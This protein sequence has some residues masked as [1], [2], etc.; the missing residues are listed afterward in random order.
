MNT[1]SRMESTGQR[2]KIQVSQ[3]TADL[4]LSFNKGSWLKKR[5]D[6]DSTPSETS[7]WLE[8]NTR[9]SSVKSGSTYP[10]S[11]PS[12]KEDVSCSLSRD[13]SA[14]FTPELLARDCSEYVDGA[15][16]LDEKTQRMVNWITRLLETLLCKVI[17]HRN[18]TRGSQLP[19]A[20][21]Q[22]TLPTQAETK[23]TVIDEVQDIIALPQQKFPVPERPPE[24][25]LHLG[26]DVLDQL[27]Y[28]VSIIASKYKA[29]AFHNFGKATG[30]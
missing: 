27:H 17:D 10:V 6:S 8:M 25:K 18:A 13:V 23:Q 19:A 11:E 16:C 9:S 20:E 3:E 5:D 2:G 12:S 22:S 4:L 15:V 14:W 30:G 28:Y 24:G 21:G 1:A 26:K 29:N 7:Y